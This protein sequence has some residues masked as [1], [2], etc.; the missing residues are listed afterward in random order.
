MGGV[1]LGWVELGWLGGWKA[2]LDVGG[3]EDSRHL[4]GRGQ[5]L[6]LEGGEARAD[7]RAGQRLLCVC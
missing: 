6:L 5:A 1:G 7:F 3:L 4:A 2:Y